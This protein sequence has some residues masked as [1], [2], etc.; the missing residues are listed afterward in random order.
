MKDGNVSGGLSFVGRAVL[1]IF[2]LIGFYALSLG[3]AGLLLYLP[4]AE[5]VYANRLHIKLAIG[6]VLIAACII[7][8]CIFV[9]RPKFEPP[10]PELHASDEP[11]LFAL[12]KEV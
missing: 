10:G 1:S 2:L 8:G 9:P 11:A 4:Y 12:I 3:I 5:L 7:K 6:A